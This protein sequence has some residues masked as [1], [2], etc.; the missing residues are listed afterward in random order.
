MGETSEVVE[1]GLGNRTSKFKDIQVWRSSDEKERRLNLMRL[2]NLNQFKSGNAVTVFFFIYKEYFRN[3]RRTLNI[4]LNVRE[5][6]NVK[7][8]VECEVTKN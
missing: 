5:F 8:L 1:E 3:K 2:L 4:F 7:V 6:H